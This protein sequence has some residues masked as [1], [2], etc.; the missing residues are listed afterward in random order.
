MP[1]AAALPHLAREK[2]ADGSERRG[3]WTLQLG[4]WPGRPLCVTRALLGRTTS[5]AAQ[6]V[7][8]RP[9][10]LAACTQRHAQRQPAMP[11]ALS[12]FLCLPPAPPPALALPVLPGTLSRCWRRQQTEGRSP[13]PGWHPEAYLPPSAPWR[14][15]AA[16]QRA[17]PSEVLTVRGV[18]H[19][20]GLPGCA[21]C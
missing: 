13:R 12:S 4:P 3:G 7:G 2:T 20:R 18:L 21:F 14:S 9:Q 19:L 8:L 17:A 10:R 15:P 6:P 16:S 5:Q 1:N 11:P